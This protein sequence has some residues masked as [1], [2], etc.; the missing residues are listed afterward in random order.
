MPDVAPRD[1]G[2]V[3]GNP[4]SRTWDRP[5]VPGPP[6][7]TSPSLCPGGVVWRRVM[8]RDI[9]D[10]SVG[11]SLTLGARLVVAVAVDGQAA[12]EAG[13]AED[14][15]VVAAGDDEELVA[16]EAGA[17]AD[18]VLAPVDEVVGLDGVEAG[19]RDGGQGR[20]GRGWLGCG[21]PFGWR[22]A[23]EGAVGSVVVVERD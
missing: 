23:S 11:T 12:D 1:V 6:C 7:A 9:A 2:Q 17:D 3:E 5:C 8:C 21:P 10:T 19:V 13:R 4:A 15:D 14:G 18:A 16:G 22:V 20:P